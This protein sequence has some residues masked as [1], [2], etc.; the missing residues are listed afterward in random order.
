MA[1]IRSIK[2]EFWT[3][4]KVVAV[5]HSARLLFI[6]LWNFSDDSGNLENNPVQIKMRVLPADSC[7]VQPLLQELVSV[8]LLR[9]YSVN[10]KNYLNIKGFKDHQVINK[11]SKTRLPEP[12]TTVVL[13]DGRE[14]SGSGSGL[15]K[16]RK[17]SKPGGG[18]IVDN[19]PKAGHQAGETSGDQALS[20]LTP[21]SPG[22]V[23][24]EEQRQL[25]EVI[26]RR[27][28]EAGSFV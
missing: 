9:E 25:R 27:R 1:R 23:E 4:E 20:G 26:E 17:G 2:P 10:G 15:G 22:I 11:P 21:L 5:S 24:T 13:P 14:G 7:S 16:E 6:G 19:S 3:D 28:R 8:G 18:G 12:P